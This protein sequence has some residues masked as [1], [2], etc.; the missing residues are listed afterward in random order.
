M[1]RAQGKAMLLR[2]TLLTFLSS[3]FLATNALA[4]V[5]WQRYKERFLSPDGRI[6]DTGNRSISH[7]EG[8]GFGML[9]AIAAEDKE[10]FDKLW[11]WTEQYLRNPKTDLFYWKYNPAAANPIEDK[12]N[13]SDGDL[14]I[15]WALLKAGKKWNEHKYLSASNRILRALLKYTV[16]DFAG[17]KVMLP[18]KDGFSFGT[19]IIL[20]PSYFIY[21][22]WQDL[23]DYTHLYDLHKLI[24][25]T[26]QI[27]QQ[28][29]W[30]YHQIATDWITL[31]ADGKTSPAEQWPARA[32]YDAIRVPVYLKWMTSD[33]KLLGRWYALFDKYPRLQTPAWENIYGGEKANY[34][35]SGGLLAVRDLTMGELSAT[36]TKVSRYEDYYSASLKLLVALASQRF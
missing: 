18:G 26:Q 8:Q 20:N 11:Q 19:H 31:Y 27:M 35:M 12:N 5:D 34:P 21:P 14:L 3:L 16:I 36:S 2:L 1:L 22:A 33:N 10:S 29:D 25:D 9:F 15:A 28:I 30:G 32:S 23:A 7:S 24:D 4:S 6:I 17:K 13:A